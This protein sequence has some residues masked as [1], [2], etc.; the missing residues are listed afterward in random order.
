MTA[1]ASSRPNLFTIGAAK[2][3]TTSL[4]FQLDRHPHV[5]MSRPKEPAFFVPEIDAY[6]KDPDWYLGLFAE[7]GDARVV[8]ESSTHYTKL[9]I[10][11]GVPQRIAE[12]CDDPR[13][14]YVVRD[15]IDRIISQYWHDSRQ[16]VEHRPM[17]AAVRE[18][19]KYTAISDYR[20]QLEPYVE[21]F[22]RD[23]VRVLVFE[24]L[25]EHPAKVLE[26][27]FRWL[28]LDPGRVPVRL[29]KKN[30]RPETV[31]V[32]RDSGLLLRFA[33]SGLWNT[34]SP[35]APSFLKEVGNR[36]AF[37]RVRPSEVDVEEVVEY[38][39]PGQRA[40]VAEL[41]DYLGRDFP[42]WT[43]TLGDALTPSGR[44][45]EGAR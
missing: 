22:G 31:R 41:S 25:V 7:A 43:T 34:L 23:R 9:P 1:T 32:T 36:L 20:R 13:F 21:L 39:R 3:G 40:K 18:D 44:G 17:L 15:P 37:K 19:E 29:P 38:L 24:E 27:V 12:F 14:L 33:R 45:E 6:P 2:A 35:Y 28:G 5:F 16:W 11:P 42:Q 10:Y 8:G 26:G 30:T 4:H